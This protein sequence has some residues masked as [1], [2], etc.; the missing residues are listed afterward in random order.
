MA[1]ALGT[2][3]HVEV[4]VMRKNL[5]TYGKASTREKQDKSRVLKSKN[6]SGC[7]RSKWSGIL[8]AA[9]RPS[10]TETRK[11][12]GGEEFKRDCKREIENSPLRQHLTYFIIK[13][14]EWCMNS[15]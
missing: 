5:Q 10:K 6:G 4:M 3:Q 13:G 8:K 2:L 11:W 14:E 12:G 1:W 9:D 15:A 7:R